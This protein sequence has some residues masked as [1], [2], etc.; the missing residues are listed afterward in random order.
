M[1]NT[2]RQGGQAS[3]LVAATQLATVKIFFGPFRLARFAP[4]NAPVPQTQSKADVENP[5]S[6]GFVA[7]PQF[8]QKQ[9]LFLTLIRPF[10]VQNGF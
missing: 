1:Q 2:A 5:F 7:S 6:K 4:S 9:V 8:V 3:S 10:I